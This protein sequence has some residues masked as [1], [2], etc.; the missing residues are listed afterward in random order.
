ME[1]DANQKFAQIKGIRVDISAWSVIV[2]EPEHD[3][4]DDAILE[5]ID[6]NG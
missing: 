2:V 6:E 3:L 5:F 1:T 4:E